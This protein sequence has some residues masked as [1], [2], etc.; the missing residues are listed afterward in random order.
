MPQLSP[1]SY[2]EDYKR[3]LTPIELADDDDD[4]LPILEDNPIG[5]VFIEEK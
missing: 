3:G 2:Y 5:K 1:S 4:R